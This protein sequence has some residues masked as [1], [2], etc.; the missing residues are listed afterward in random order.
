M[1]IDRLESYD[2]NDNFVGI[3]VDLPEPVLVDWPSS[4]FRQLTPN[5]KVPPLTPANIESYFVHRVACDW[6][7]TGD[8]KALTKGRL[9]V[10]SH[11][12]EACSLHAG[13]ESCAAF[14]SGIVK[15]AMKKKVCDNVEYG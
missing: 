11:R 9:L 4:G 5:D 1:C 15:A 2:R 14:V 6:Q 12:V 13:S 3:P 7:Q 8:M 10:D